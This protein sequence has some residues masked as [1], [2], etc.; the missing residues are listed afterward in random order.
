MIFFRT[1][2]KGVPPNLCLGVNM[3]LKNIMLMPFYYKILES[4]VSLEERMKLF[5]D[6]R[7]CKICFNAVADVVFVPCG[8]LCSCISCAE[9]LRKCPICRVKIEKATKTYIS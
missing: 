4:S 8:H 6:Q 5:E 2:L 1:N 7:Q 9:S 3:L